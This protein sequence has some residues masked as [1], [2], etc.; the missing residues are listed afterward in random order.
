MNAEGSH[1]REKLSWIVI[2]AFWPAIGIA[3][4]GAGLISD[5]GTFDLHRPVQLF[6]DWMTWVQW[7]LFTVPILLLA[8]WIRRHTTGASAIALHVVGAGCFTL[9][10]LATYLLVVELVRGP[11]PKGLSGVLA[12]AVARF[13]RHLLYNPLIYGAIV[14][15]GFAVHQYWCREV[16]S[17]EKAQMEKLVAEAELDLLRAQI[18][19]SFILATLA[20]IDRLVSEDVDR[21]E[22]AILRL[23]D[24]LRLGLKNGARSSSSVA[25]EVEIVRARLDVLKVAFPAA[26]GGRV[27]VDPAALE[28]AMPPA[29]LQALADYAIGVARSGEFDL[30]ISR[31]GQRLVVRMHMETADEGLTS[32]REL[33]EVQ[34]MLRRAYGS[35]IGLRHRFQGEATDLEFSLPLV[36]A[37]VDWSAEV[38]Q[39]SNREHAQSPDAWRVPE[40]QR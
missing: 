24:F 34:S 26:R 37:N 21:A 36:R 20:A 16:R 2:A 31:D 32:S 6:L 27:I 38:A 3:F 8:G 12:V 40:L 33:L 35:G 22:E 1:P 4:M 17:H 28:C 30:A 25:D 9:L 10:H 13:P 15:A 5:P 19:P 14:L 39:A 29:F 23:S 18:Q 11:D 7:A